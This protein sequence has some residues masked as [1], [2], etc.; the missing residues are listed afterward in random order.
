[1]GKKSVKIL[2]LTVCVALVCFA[3]WFICAFF[4]NPLSHS[5]SRTSADQYLKENFAGTDYEIVDSGFDMKTG[6]Y[7]VDVLSPGSRDS[8]FIIYCDGFGRYR[9]NT[10]EDV[11]S[12][13]NTFARLN[14]DYWNLIK[15]NLPYAQF[16]ISIG[17]GELR[18][19][20]YFE[21][22]NYTDDA[23]ELK[24]Y[25]YWKDYGLDISTLVLDGEYDILQLGR[26]HGK[27][28]LYIH[29]PEVS[30]ERA[31]ALLLAFK[32][33]MDEQGV[34]F[35]AID[36]HLCEPRNEQGQNAGQQLNLYEFLYS[37][38][39]EEGLVDRVRMY[40]NA[41]QEHHAIQDGN[42]VN[43]DLQYLEKFEIPED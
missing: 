4:G 3:V 37:E 10:Y 17:F 18:A 30:V 31:A 34:P 23:G 15:Q 1:M 39:Y 12:G 35:H 9:A 7:Y 2:A 27:L 8:H 41:A 24:E 38:I 42:K 14:S 26:D 20:G 33:H 19:A 11:T 36:F 25:T 5:L 40:W 22:F 16:D 32:A 21:V 13:Y 29:D 6:G 43:S 28:C